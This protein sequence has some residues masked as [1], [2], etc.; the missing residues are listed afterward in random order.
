[1]TFYTRVMYVPPTPLGF[2][3]NRWMVEHTCAICRQ[4]VPTD[5]LVE[6]AKGHEAGQSA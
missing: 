5:Q 4:D 1:M 2:A 3:G 6:H